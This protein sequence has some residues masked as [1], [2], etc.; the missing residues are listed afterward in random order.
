MANTNTK[1]RII[2]IGN[3]MVGYKFCERLYEKDT[4]KQ[5]HIVTFCEEPRVAYDRVHLSEYFDGKS[6]ED[7]S[8]ASLSWYE[9]R[10]I[11]IHIK[12]KVVTIDRNAKTVNSAKGVTCSYDKIVMATGSDAF[13]PPIPGKEKDGVF[14]YRTIE[15][16]DAI[17]D[18]ANKSKSC[19]IIG[20]GLLGLE[21]AKAAMDLGL[22]TDVVEFAPRLMARQVDE[23]GGEILK[24]IIEQR[25]IGVHLSKSTQNIAGEGNVT[26]MEFADETSLDIDMIIVSAGIKPRDELA[27][28]AGLTI[29]ERGGILVNNELLTSD[30]NIFAIG[31]CALYQK[32]IYGLVAPGYQ[33]ADIVSDRLLGGNSTFNGADMSTKL[34]LLGTDVASFGQTDISQEASDQEITINDPHTGI[35]KK[36]IISGDGKTLKGGI[37]VGDATAYGALLQFYKNGTVLPP[38]PIQL[39][40]PAS[41]GEPVGTSVIDLPDTA[42][43]CSCENVSKGTICES[44][45]NGCA[46]VAEL[47]ACT[48]AGTGC[49]GCVPLMT[50]LFK[51]KMKESGVE[52]SKA[53]CE[54]FDLSRTEM[55]EVVRATGIRTFS[56]LIAKHGRGDHRG[57]CEICKPA[58]ASIFASIWN[59]PILKHA[60]LQDSNDTFLANIQNDGTYSIIPRIPG[61]EITPEKLI[62]IG[63]VAKK[64]D[65]YTKI[66]GGQRIVL[67]GAKVH[68]LPDIWKI[69]IDAGFESGHAYGKAL[70]TV[71]SCVGSSWCRFGVQ[72]STT[73]AIKIEERYRGIRSPHKIKS[74]VSGGVREGAEARSK[75]FGIIAT[76]KGWNLYIAGNGG[77]NPRHADLFASDIDE[78]TLIQYID[79]FLM[80]Y[81]KTAD[82]L[83]RTSTWMNKLEGGLNHVKDVV[84]NDSLGIAE[85]LESQ[86]QHLVD[87][88]ECEWKNA[89]NDTEKLK[90]FKHFVNTDDEDE[91]VVFVRDRG[92]KRP[93]TDAEKPPSIACL[94]ASN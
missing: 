33:M 85:D 22:K 43:I 34:K 59:E 84:I 63:E 56:E 78:K 31:E 82:R 60:P 68:Q 52:V 12:D 87:T 24:S 91:T 36:L 1:E 29:G 25:G 93:A 55:Y 46:S 11:E 17:R 41:D 74:A 86:M 40:L 35:Y 27:R 38:E 21:A 64:F 77:M 80:Y 16:L 7:L 20:G 18:Y 51:E 58:A 83:E 26:R 9:E 90:R 73:L 28:N 53:I 13:L 3:G 45:E 88:Y 32:M 54:H 49:G 44:I 2:V 4:A 10:G 37:L 61:G 71:K 14:V 15:D 81:I 72:Y 75:D 94:S 69:L 70:R 30:P 76:E 92:Q 67:L 50:D 6:A 62:I 42:Q 48:K 66:T 89:L 19:A 39:I 8:M 57:G 23:A 79:R 47:K 5:F 65:L